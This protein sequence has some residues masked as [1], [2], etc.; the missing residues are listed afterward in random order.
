MYLGPIRHKYTALE[1][2]ADQGICHY[3]IPRFTRV[4]STSLN[5]DDINA[6][7]KLVAESEVRNRQIIDDVCECVAAQR[8]PV[9]LTRF[10]EHARLIYNSL[11]N[12]AQHV[13]IM[14]GDNTP[15]E[16]ALI[17]DRLLSVPKPESL[18]LI[19]TGQIIG[20]W[21][22]FPRL[23]TLM[24]AAPVSFPGRLEQY[25]GRLNRDFEGKY[26]VIVYDYV[27]SHL[28]VF[29]NMFKKRLR[30]YKKIGFELMTDVLTEKQSTNAI[31]TS[32]DY[33]EVFEQDLVE[34]DNEIV[35][36]SPDISHDK[37]ERF[38]N[39]M[40][41]RLEKGVKVTIITENPDN[42]IFGNLAYVMELMQHLR[43]N[44]IS[45]GLS[46]NANEHYAVID[47][48]L[49]WHGGMNLL[50]KADVWDNLIRVKDIQAATELIEI[51]FTGTK[52]YTELY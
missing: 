36:S 6:S 49:V 21:F 29:N 24:L 2:A 22:N 44:G 47:K 41:P 13:F 17:K 12:Y 28:S 35:I 25:V 9:I 37:I 4:V 8:T 7:Y 52:L 39:I 15:K 40:K 46:D 45:I 16:N 19:A 3:I 26:D 43:D 48:S 1:R 50:G 31:F 20:E 27:D 23:D 14:Y 42:Q 51:S 30:T 5:Q 38:I 34:A 33:Y 10:K 32:T 11:L 18:I